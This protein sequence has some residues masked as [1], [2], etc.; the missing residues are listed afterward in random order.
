MQSIHH[1]WSILEQSPGL[2]NIM[3]EWQRRLGTTFDVAR[4]WFRPTNQRST[5]FPCPSP[6]G[7]GCPRRVVDHGNDEIVAVCNDEDQYCDKITLAPGDIIIHDLDLRALGT[8]LAQ[9][10]DFTPEFAPIDGLYQTFLLGKIQPIANRRFPVF[11]TIQR[12]KAN[13]KDAAVCLL[14]K[15]DTPFVLL[16]PT[17]KFVDTEMTTLLARNK[18]RFMPLEEIL[19]WDAEIES[20]TG[21]ESVSGWL[22]DFAKQAA[23]EITQLGSMDHFPTPSGA[24]WEHFTFEFLGDQAMLVRCKGVQQ[25][26]QLE[27]EHLGMKN[28]I[29]GKPTQQWIILMA[30]AV[31]GGQLSWRNKNDNSKLKAQKQALSKK[32]K[33]YFLLDDEPVPWKRNLSSFET[34]FVLRQYRSKNNDWFQSEM[35]NFEE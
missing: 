17:G 9:I 20:L 26:R 23:P 31:D 29:N 30:L 34:R 5:S 21:T 16:S 11:L 2:K 4:L 33:Q 28:Q 25:P 24:S 6:G 7:N 14:A 32:L 22:T 19:V 10:F 8:I 13:M 35:S 1:L 12:D 15:T 3:P 18:S 27:P